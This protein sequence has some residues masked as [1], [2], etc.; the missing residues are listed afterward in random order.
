LNSQYFLPAIQR[1]YVWGPDQVIKLFDSLMRGYPIGSFLFWELQP[2]NRD[3]WEIYKFVDEAFESGTHNPRGNASGVHNLTLIL[4]GQQRLTSLLIGLKGSYFIKKK[5]RRRSDPSAWVRQYLYL[6]LLKDPKVEPEDGETGVRYGFEF[7]ERA[8][9]SD[10]KHHWLRVGRVLDFSGQDSFDEFKQEEED[11]LPGD[12]TR[13]QVA[14]FRR[15]LDRLYRLVWKDEAIA[16][17]T[18]RDQDYDRVLDIF[19]RANEGGTK[20]SKSDL[21]LS[22]VT[23]KWG[24]VDA[25]EEIYGFVDRLNN[26]LERKNAFD[27]DFVMKTCLVLSDLPVQY[28]VENFNNKNLTLIEA[29]WKSIKEAIETAVILV[30]WFGIDRDNLTSANAIIPVAY[31]LSQQPGLTLRGSTAFDVSNAARIRTWLTVALLNNVFGGQS[32]RVLTEIRRIL[33][34]QTQDPPDFPISALSEGVAR[35]G[36]SATF[37]DY[38]LESFLALTYGRQTTFLALSLLYDD[39][40]WGT[41]TYHVDHIFPRALF[42]TKSMTAAGL[43]PSKQISYM[44]LMNQVGNLELLLSHENVEKSAMDFQAWLPTRDSSFRLRH[45]IPQDDCLL[46]FDRFEEFIKARQA[47][48]RER[49]DKILLVG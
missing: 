9:K 30:N 49:L 37:D 25:R 31:Y 14:V 47:L 43:S 4:D 11:K 3:K 48:I 12:V 1:E 42:T 41:V 45:L 28:K 17:Y 15:N 40:S 13:G 29:R 2:E 19:V 38:A 34:D 46:S 39:N 10:A 33:I 22:M 27:K 16:S 7:F 8:P 23:S 20:L 24:S 21:L 6:D 26:E 36:K 35:A 32:D 44:G 18:E 5:Y